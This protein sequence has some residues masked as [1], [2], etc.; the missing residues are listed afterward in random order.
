MN[1]TR[2]SALALAAALFAAATPAHADRA[3]LIG[4]GDYPGLAP[5]LR[6]AAPAEDA[7]RLRDALVRAGFP[8][9]DVTMMSDAEG[10]SPTRDAVLAELARAAAEARPHEQVLVYFSGHGAQAPGSASAPD[11]LDELY[12]LRDARG[13]DG[14]RM[15]VPGAISDGELSAALDAIRARGADLWFVADTCHAAGL[16]RGAGAAGTRAK[17]V[18]RAALHIPAALPRGTPAIPPAARLPGAFTAF[19]AAARDGIAV[20]RRL[21]PGSPDARPLSQFSYALTRAIDAGRLRSLRDLAIA[22]NA[23]DASL[24]GDAPQPVYEGALDRPVLHLAADRVRRYPAVRDGA[25]LQLSA[26]SE[27]GIASGDRFRLIDTASGHAIGEARVRQARIGAATL[28]TDAPPPP[29]AIEAEPLVAPIAAGIARS[30]FLEAV[31][32]LAGRGAARGLVVQARLWR[33]GARPRCPELAAAGP[34]ARETRALD[35][36]APPPLG[37]CDV[38]IAA[39]RNGGAAAVDLS[40]FYVAADGRLVALSFLQDAGPDDA[41]VRIA[42]GERREVAIRLLS[43]SPTHAPLATGSERLLL[44]ALPATAATPTD[45]RGIAD[46]G[47]LRGPAPRAPD[48]AGAGALV[49]RWTVVPRVTAAKPVGVPEIASIR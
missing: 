25:A 2:R 9:R 33:P 43:E 15:R 48:T 21:P 34:P 11:G 19:Y 31:A 27:E 23:A 40:P 24:G 5:E 41:G 4:T 7:R 46:T 12:L 8:A 20:E 17:G 30:R 45:L 49:Y 16:T 44:V 18:E 6:L 13:W 10:I 47:D 36:L 38:V 14:G 28:A 32:P 39:I 26:G 29:G 37:Q 42:P 3:I 22:L 35:L 1:R